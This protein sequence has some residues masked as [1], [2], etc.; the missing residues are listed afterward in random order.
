MRSRS[1]LIRPKSMAT[2]VV[3]FCGKPARSSTWEP[4]EVMTA[5]VVSGTIS[6]T[7]PTN[8]V[9]PAPK[10]PAITILTEVSL[11]APG[12][13]RSE[14]AESTEHLLKEGEVGAAVRSTR[15]VDHHQAL[16]GKIADEHPGDTE[17]NGQQCRDLRNRTELAAHGE[18]LPAFRGSQKLQLLTGGGGGDEGFDGQVIPRPRPATGHGVRPDQWSRIASGTRHRA[19]CHGI[20]EAVPPAAR[21]AAPASAHRPPGRPAGPSRTP[22]APRRSPSRR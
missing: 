7:E 17:R 15:L 9:F 5:S 8:V 6:D 4:A 18:D 14:V 11:A 19:P 21:R 12:A 16:V 2:V 20:T 1:R 22:P 10:P 3:V 13:P